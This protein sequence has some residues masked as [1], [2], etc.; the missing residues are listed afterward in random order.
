MECEFDRALARIAQYAS[1]LGDV[2]EEADVRAAVIRVAF[3]REQLAQIEAL[4]LGDPV[5][6]SDR[7]ALCSVYHELGRTEPPSPARLDQILW[8]VVGGE[9]VPGLRACRPRRSGPGLL[10]RDAVV[11]EVTRELVDALRAPITR[12][13]ELHRGVVLKYMLRRGP[14]V[15]AFAAWRSA[16]EGLGNCLRMLGDLGAAG[17]SVLDWM[18]MALCVYFTGAQPR[19]S[20]ASIVA[21]VVELLADP[22][23]DWTVHALLPDVGELAYDPLLGIILSTVRRIS[24]HPSWQ[25]IL[26]D[27]DGNFPCHA[28]RPI[29][30]D[31]LARRAIVSAFKDRVVEDAF[32]MPAIPWAT[33]ACGGDIWCSGM[34]FRRLI[35]RFMH[36]TEPAFF[37]LAIEGAPF[38]PGIG[39]YIEWNARVLSQLT[40]LFL[41]FGMASPVEGGSRVPVVVLAADADIRVVGA[42]LGSLFDCM[43]ALDQHAYTHLTPGVVDCVKTVKAAAR[44]ARDECKLPMH[45]LPEEIRELPTPLMRPPALAQYVSGQ[46]ARALR[47]LIAPC[48]L[49]Q[50]ASRTVLREKCS[51][52]IAGGGVD[53]ML[54]LARREYLRTQTMP[55]S[56]L[57]DLN[58]LW[59]MCPDEFQWCVRC[60]RSDSLCMVLLALA[61]HFRSSNE[62]LAVATTRKIIEAMS[63]RQANL[64]RRVL[65]TM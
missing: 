45:M 21:R 50:D 47:P 22:T 64:L 27:G 14:A 56:W 23:L 38:P 58:G 46:W 28:L 13:W 9:G 26:I 39:N 35:A 3:D 36:T 29:A 44:T 25:Q 6:V 12:N 30:R 11:S 37:S 61:K 48:M 32:D 17:L 33:A 24:F 19:D 62:E 15:T 54:D 18:S 57:H 55:E 42:N 59:A 41:V 2:A 10:V 31:T 34:L 65:H 60:S 20:R 1:T 4:A 16:M 49:G 63:E 7:W 8:L 52:A 40:L 53:T 43:S 5:E 51:L